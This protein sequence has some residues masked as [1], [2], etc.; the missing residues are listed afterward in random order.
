MDV[1]PAF[2]LD[3]GNSPGCHWSRH[4][5]PAR[6]VTRKSWI[7]KIRR[8]KDIT[9]YHLQ[10]YRSQLASLGK[11]PV[12]AFHRPGG[13]MWNLPLRWRLPKLSFHQS[14]SSLSLWP[15]PRGLI[16]RGEVHIGHPQ[17]RHG[18]DPMRHRLVGQVLCPGGHL[19]FNFLGPYWGGDAADCDC[20]MMLL[21]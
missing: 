4:P 12:G 8:W 21:S 13:T 5:R 2:Q 3:H 15:H 19:K 7:I 16:H 6:H 18:S 11:I 1:S 14:L 10:D 20:S 9:W 17:L